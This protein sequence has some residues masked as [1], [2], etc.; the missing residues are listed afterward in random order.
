MEGTN[1]IPE[2]RGNLTNC[3]LRQGVHASTGLE[4]AEEAEVVF[5]ESA[6]VGG[7]LRPRPEAL[8]PAPS[9]VEGRQAGGTE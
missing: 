1:P 3:G 5:A 4:L 8:E 9:E 6:E 2:F 7:G